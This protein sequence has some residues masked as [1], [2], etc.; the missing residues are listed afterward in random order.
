MEIINIGVIHSPY[1][2]PGDAPNQGCF[3]DEIMQLEIYPQFLDGLK[4]IERVT[5]LIVLYWCHLARRDVLQTKTPY[6][7]KIR[8]VFACRSPARPNPI[9]FCV[10]KLLEVKGDRL[11][12][13]GIE[14]VDGSPIVDIKPY[15]TDIDSI[16]DASIGWFKK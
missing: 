4:D 16:H 10:A 5:H 15:S 14:A 2:S 6:G 8:G 7:S 9:A 13:R 1:K 11:F 12:V 3:S